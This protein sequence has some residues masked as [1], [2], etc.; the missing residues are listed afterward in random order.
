VL[1]CG[2]H[3]SAKKEKGEDTDLGGGAGWAMGRFLVWVEKL[4]IGPFFLFPF[5]FFSLFFYVFLFGNFR[6]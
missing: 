5:L 6:N 4:P 2:S 1:T 3:L